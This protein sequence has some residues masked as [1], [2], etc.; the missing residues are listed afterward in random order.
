LFIDNGESERKVRLSG[1]HDQIKIARDMIQ[2]MLSDAGSMRANESLIIKIPSSKV[3]LVIGRKGET[4]RDFEERS[5]AKI[6]M[7]SDASA[8]KDNERTITLVGDAAAVQHAKTLIED[9]LYGS[10]NGE[11]RRFGQQQP[12][13]EYGDGGRYGAVMPRGGGSGR[14][15][16]EH[17]SIRVPVKYVGLIIGKRKLKYLYSSQY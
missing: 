4:I 9:I 8:D 3:G 7:A 2:Q 12:S 10:D 16:E 17:E 15:N 14:M 11:A 1:E 13:A 5:K 6:L